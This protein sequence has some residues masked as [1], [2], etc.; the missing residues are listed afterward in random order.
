MLELFSTHPP[1]IAETSRE[2]I[3]VR[4]KLMHSENAA[5][6][7]VITMISDLFPSSLNP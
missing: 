6:L 1:I 7:S 2:I 5:V 3:S 4:I